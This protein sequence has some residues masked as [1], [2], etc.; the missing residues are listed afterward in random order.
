MKN[1]KCL[2]DSLGTSKLHRNYPTKQCLTTTDPSTALVTLSQDSECSL[3][4]ASNITSLI[5]IFFYKS[6]M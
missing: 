3:L 2:E 1:P 6:Y 4:Q 5:L